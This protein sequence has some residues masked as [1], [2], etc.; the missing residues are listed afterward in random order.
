MK[1]AVLSSHTP[2]LFWFRMDMMKSFLAKGHE[3]IAVGDQDEDSWKA[4]FLE[5]G[6]SY[7]KADI[8]RN[9]TNPLRDLKTLSSLKRILAEEQPGKIFTYQAKT[10]IYGTLAA[11]AVGIKEVY[12][13]IAG[14]GSVFLADSLKAKLVRMILKTEYRYS[15]RN[16]SH[17]FFQNKDDVE[18]FRRHGIL[19]KQS[20]V[21]LHGSGVNLERF[22]V[23]QQPEQFAFLYIGRLIRDKGI[24][25]YLEACKKVKKQHPQVRCLLV[26]PFDTNPSALR[27]EEL[28]PYLDDGTI[29]Y[30]GE[31]T[32][33]RPY[34]AQ[35]SV[36]V[37][38]SYHEGTPKTVLE[39]MACQKAIITT[40]APGCR[41]T[42]KD[43]KNGFLVPVKDVEALAEKMR[44][45]I[46][47]PETVGQMAAE[48]RK[49]AEERFDV[50]LVNQMIEKTMGL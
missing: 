39:A 4:K 12:P 13:L 22:Q 37:L 26:G 3:V 34:L 31:Q 8:Q 27:R 28:Q 44:I 14:V 32:D 41:E 17:V 21:L 35:C 48:S 23:Q 20:V 11:N 29:E 6:I 9:G 25:E 19:K 38:P 10:I 45:C 43:G 7:R 5:N 1:I 33:V 50:R 36:F 2:S 24:M 30:F 16:C 18:V 46:D 47:D 40:D 49:M 42:V 15:M